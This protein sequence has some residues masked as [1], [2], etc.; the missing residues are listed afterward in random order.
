MESKHTILIVDDEESIL[1]SLQRVFHKEGYELITARSGQEGLARLKEEGKEFSLIISDQRMPGMNGVEFLE[2]AKNIFPQAARILLTG[3]SDT[4]AV[5]EAI[6]KGG[7]HRYMAKPW[8][9]E[10]LLFHVHQALKQ[11]DLVVEN[12]KLL[13]LTKEQ[14]EELKELNLHLEE[15]VLQRTSEINEK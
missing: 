6:N 2:K 8:N 11:Y 13:A 1:N 7:I 9:E 12:Q 4:E 10:E 14:N 5:V 3:Y 15:K